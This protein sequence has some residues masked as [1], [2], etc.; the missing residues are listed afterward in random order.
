MSNENYTTKEKRLIEYLGG[1][2]A[3]KNYIKEHSNGKYNPNIQQIC[4][5]YFHGIPLKHLIIMFY[6]VKD[7]SKYKMSD[8]YPD[9]FKD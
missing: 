1:P 6:A 2:T 3:V 7:R 8:F 9:I 5:W 4:S